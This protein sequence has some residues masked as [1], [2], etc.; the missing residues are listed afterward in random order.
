LDVASRN[1][2]NY[3]PDSIR[4]PL[5][6]YIDNVQLGN[7][8]RFGQKLIG[9]L[10]R[11]D[12]SYLERI[13]FERIKINVP[14]ILGK[15][16]ETMKSNQSRDFIKTALELR[17]D[18]K[19]AKV[20]EILQI[21]DRVLRYGYKDDI[22][23]LS[24]IIKEMKN[25]SDNA[26]DSGLYSKIIG[27][28]DKTSPVIAGLSVFTLGQVSPIDDKTIQA[29]IIGSTTATFYVK[30][31]YSYFKRPRIQYLK[32]LGKELIQIKIYNNDL[33]SIFGSKLTAE[34]IHQLKTLNAFQ[35]SYLDM[36]PYRRASLF[37]RIQTRIGWR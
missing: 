4:V 23:A 14:S 22:S 27:V 35:H 20:R 17:E 9:I 28:I 29:M 21:Q 12:A 31:L 3:C 32:D 16:L 30:K 10:G 25:F 1:Q 11:Q 7:I 33:N 18:K 37:G 6:E 8:Q 24:K 2:F 5:V 26:E 15:I 36:P 34:N 19:F 13:S